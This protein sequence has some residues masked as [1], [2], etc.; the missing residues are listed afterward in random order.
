MHLFKSTRN[1][2]AV[3]QAVSR[4]LPTAAARVLSQVGHVE[5]VVDKLA[6]GYVFFEYFR[7]PCQ[8]SFHQIL[9]IHLS[10]GAGTMG[11]LLNEVPSGLSLNPP[12]KILKRAAR[13]Q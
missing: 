9:H 7:F 1:C 3:A 13:T 10:S 12:L 5:F 8:L 6:L 2:R 4:R 11:Q